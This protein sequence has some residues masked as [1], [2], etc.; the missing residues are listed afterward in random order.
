MNILLVAF[1]LREVANNQADHRTAGYY[2]T[3]LVEVKQNSFKIL[4]QGLP[5][6]ITWKFIYKFFSNPAC[7]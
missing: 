3:S 6:K 2:I 7:W 1:T 5:L 4:L